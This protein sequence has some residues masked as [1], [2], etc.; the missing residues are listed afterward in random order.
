ME[1]MHKTQQQSMTPLSLHRHVGLLFTQCK[2]SLQLSV[3]FLAI[4]PSIM[5]PC[6]QLPEKLGVG[7]VEVGVMWVACECGVGV[8]PGG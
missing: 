5:F 8:G 2:A 4:S 7:V 1:G 6:L 3:D